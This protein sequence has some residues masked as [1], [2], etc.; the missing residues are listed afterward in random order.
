MCVCASV[1]CKDIRW[2]FIGGSFASFCERHAYRSHVRERQERRRRRR[3]CRERGHG[4][5][6]KVCRVFPF[7]PPFIACAP[8][9]SA[10]TLLA[11]KSSWARASATV[12]C[13]GLY[14]FARRTCYVSLTGGSFVE[15]LEHLLKRRVAVEYILQSTFFVY[16]LLYFRPAPTGGQCDTYDTM[17]VNV[18]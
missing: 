18:Y 13:N 10:H 2:P 3:R 15:V 14:A 16:V 5:L 8:P 7:G 12:E 9:R 17:H 11:Y 4:Y 1:K 6:F